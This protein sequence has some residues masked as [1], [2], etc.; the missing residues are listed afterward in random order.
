MSRDGRKWVSGY[1]IGMWVLIF[2]LNNQIGLL[3]RF[4]SDQQIQEVMEDPYMTTTQYQT[5]IQVHE[6][7]T[8]SVS[9]QIDVDFDELRHGIYRYIPQKG[10]ITEV[11]V[12]GTRVDQPYYAFF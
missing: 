4:T 7:N 10:I 8:Y 11:E 5:E 2:F 6:N 12:D 3:G 9:E 1:F